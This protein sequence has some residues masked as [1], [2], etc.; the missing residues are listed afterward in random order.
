MELSGATART[1]R[2]CVSGG[3]GPSTSLQ[4]EHASLEHK[5]FDFLKSGGGST[6][7]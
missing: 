7:S 1:E 3:P 5:G 6:R 4:I 2:D